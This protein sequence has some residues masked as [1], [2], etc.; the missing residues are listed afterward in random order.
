[1]SKDQER[2]KFS[3]MNCYNE[4]GSLAFSKVMKSSEVPREFDTSVLPLR[5][6]RNNKLYIKHLCMNH[7]FL[8]LLMINLK[9]L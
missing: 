7:T 5:T 4:E 9:I 2:S 1:M 3:L 8:L 6:I